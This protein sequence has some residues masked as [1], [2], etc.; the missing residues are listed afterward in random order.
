MQS[1]NDHRE[2]KGHD[3]Y[4]IHLYIDPMHSREGT[5]PLSRV[6]L[7]LLKWTPVG[8]NLSKTPCRYPHCLATGD[9]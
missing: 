1:K 4:E 8:V 7:S 3:I 6:T 9:H 5:D 2:V